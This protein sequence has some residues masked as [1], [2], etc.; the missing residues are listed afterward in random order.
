MVDQINQSGTSSA[1]M[2]K[3]YI[4]IQNPEQLN[5]N[6]ADELIESS[7]EKGLGLHK[8]ENCYILISLWQQ[9]TPQKKTGK[10]TE[11]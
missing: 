9:T 1:N 7:V 5:F 6:D 4:N 8:L 11:T 3:R 10:S 2:S